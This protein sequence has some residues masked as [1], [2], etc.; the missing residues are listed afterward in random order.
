M[1]KTY[2][3]RYGVEYRKVTLNL[4]TKAIDDVQAAAKRGFR[5]ISAEMEMLIQERFSRPVEMGAG[6]DGAGSEMDSSAAG[7]A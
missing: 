4:S 1:V 5:S 7:P 3:N 2:T 6:P